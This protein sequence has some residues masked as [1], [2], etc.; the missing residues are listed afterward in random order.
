[1]AGKIYVCG[2]QQL[3]LCKLVKVPC[4]KSTR[5]R[6]W[7]KPACTGLSTLWRRVPGAWL[8]NCTFAPSHM[9]HFA[10]PRSQWLYDSATFHYRKAR[11]EHTN[12]L[13]CEFEGELEGE[14]GKAGTWQASTPR[15]TCCLSLLQGL[16]TMRN[17]RLY[18]LQPVPF[19]QRRQ[20]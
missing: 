15:P 13:S 4:G 5:S 6:S 17:A 12:K 10:P 3:S 9:F 16:C 20:W 11:N 8:V 14:S 2:A 7:K 18:K 19:V 1:M